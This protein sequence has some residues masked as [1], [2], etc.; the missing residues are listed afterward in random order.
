MKTIYYWLNRLFILYLIGSHQPEA[1]AQ[2]QTIPLQRV[3]INDKALENELI[4]IFRLTKAK[5]FMVEL[6]KQNNAYLYRVHEL[7]FFEGIDKTPS[8]G[9]WRNRILL[10][11]AG[12]ELSEVCT[13]SDTTSFSNLVKYTRPLLPNMVTKEVTGRQT[14]YRTQLIEGHVWD[15]KLEN[16]KEVYLQDNYGY[17][18]RDYPHIPDPK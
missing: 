15:F 3:A 11:F 13:I 17:D 1:I 7:F 6:K 8:W 14:V 12:P 9:Q 5:V 4:D 16:G 2:N 18:S 10:F